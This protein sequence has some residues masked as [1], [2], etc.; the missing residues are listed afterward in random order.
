[1]SDHLTQIHNTWYAELK[2]PKDVQLMLGKTVFRQ[3]LKT[4]DKRIAQQRKLSLVASWKAEIAKARGMTDPLDVVAYT[5][6][7]GLSGSKDQESVELVLSD[8]VEKEHEKGR[9]T[10][11]EARR[12]VEVATGKRSPTKGFLADWEA[13]LGGVTP[14]TRTMMI[15]DAKRFAA[16]FPDIQDVT[17]KAV[18]TWTSSLLADGLSSKTVQRIVSAVRSFWHHVQHVEGIEAD[19]FVG[20]IPKQSGKKSA[21]GGSY[22]PWTPTQVV[23]LWRKAVDGKDRA[24]ADLIALAAFTGLRI[25]EACRLK[26]AD[27]EPDKSLS[28]ADSKTAAGI[29]VVPMHARIQPLVDRLCRDTADG[30]LIPSSA[31]SKYGVRSDPLSKRFGRLKTAAGF[32]GRKLVFHS[33]RKTVTTI[34]EQA[35]VPENVSA[36]IVGHEKKTM[37]YGLYSGG[38]SF[39][40]REQAVAKIAYPGWDE[41]LN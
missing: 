25:E 3:T 14:K 22:D 32:K 8:Y 13:T 40:Q 38:T 24:L 26:V 37:T 9:M 4:T 11:E 12:V 2:V 15:A 16:K 20:A 17:Q 28:V 30:Y 35:G 5:W 33:F 7:Q 29:R 31:G 6:K 41:P 39:E 34:L 18:R 21:E 10:V 1:M 19:P 36:D 23:L 27:I